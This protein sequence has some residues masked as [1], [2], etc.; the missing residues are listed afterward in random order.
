VT[1][2]YQEAARVTIEILGEPAARELLVLLDSDDAMRA[3]TFRQF[4]E[5]GGHEALRTQ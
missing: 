2:Q 4:Y 1:D 5:R 3:D